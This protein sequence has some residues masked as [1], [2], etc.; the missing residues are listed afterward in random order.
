[1][2]KISAERLED[3]V[4][5][6]SE[7]ARLLKTT[8]KDAFDA[9]MLA[10]DNIIGNALRLTSKKERDL[11][12]AEREITVNL[13]R[14]LCGRIEYARLNRAIADIPSKTRGELTEALEE[15]I[16]ATRDL[17]VVKTSSGKAKLLFFTS[18]SEAE[19]LSRSIGTRRLL[20]LEEILKSSIRLNSM[21]ANV[22]S[23][24]ANISAE[25]KMSEKH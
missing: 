17:I 23:I 11:I 21:N 25:L 9:L 15:I 24:L 20:A 19:E 8:D 16:K 7:E 3:Y 13:L 4:L 2:E 5:S 14:A 12:L 18:I 22:Q 1:M 10:S 6:A